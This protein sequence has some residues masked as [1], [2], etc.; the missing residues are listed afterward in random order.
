MTFAMTT[1]VGTGGQVLGHFAFSFGA[2]ALPDPHPHMHTIQPTH[3]GSP[4]A[5][6][7]K[8]SPPATKRDFAIRRPLGERGIDQGGQRGN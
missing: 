5:F 2:V 3:R 4:I 8:T 1:F 6:C 7:P